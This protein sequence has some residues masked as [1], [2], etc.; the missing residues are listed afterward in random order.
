MKENG[1]KIKELKIKNK[2]LN[3]SFGELFKLKTYC[4][5]LITVI[6]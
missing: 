5:L 2:P 4:S 6:R 3:R 1:V